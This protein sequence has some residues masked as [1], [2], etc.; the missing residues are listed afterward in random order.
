[1]T[2]D[3]MFQKERYIRSGILRL[4][5]ESC[6]G[7]F[8]HQDATCTELSSIKDKGNNNNNNNNNK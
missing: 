3:A 6:T 4:I 2:T 8:F 1:M 7:I 5:I